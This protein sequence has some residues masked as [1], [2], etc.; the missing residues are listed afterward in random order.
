MKISRIIATILAV[1]MLLLAFVSCNSDKPVA[2]N[3]KKEKVT[4]TVWGSAEDQ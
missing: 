1:M 3:T 2:D 4:L